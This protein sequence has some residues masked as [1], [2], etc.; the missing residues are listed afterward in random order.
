MEGND[1]MGMDW[2]F[3]VHYQDIPQLV[4]GGEG[5]VRGGKRKGRKGIKREVRE[6][7]GGKRKGRKGIER[8]VRERRG[9]KREGEG[10]RS[11]GGEGRRGGSV[12]VECWSC[13]S[14]CQCAGV[15]VCQCDV[16]HAAALTDTSR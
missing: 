2:G 5:G 14:L 8:K 15:M 10:R 7:R 1:W 12:T 13:Y 4:W 9:G 6:R 3:S 11:E 16:A